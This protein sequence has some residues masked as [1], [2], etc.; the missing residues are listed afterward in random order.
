MKNRRLTPASW[1]RAGA[2]VLAV[3]ALGGTAVAAAQDAEPPAND[4]YLNSLE[5][6]QAGTPLDHTHTLRDV[7][8]TTNAT[9]QTD[10]F[11]PPESGGGAEDTICHNVSYGKTVWYDV[12][13]DKDGTVSIR[14]SGYDN[15]I[16]FYEFDPDTLIPDAGTKHCVNRGSFPSEQMVRNV[17][18]GKS[19]TVQIGGVGDVG[20]S[21]EVLFDYAY[22]KLAKLAADATLTAGATPNGIELKG[23]S[24]KTSKKATVSVKCG[25]HCK[26]QSKKNHAVE[27]FGALKG[28]KMPAGSKLQ[29]RVTAPKSIGVYIEYRVGAGSF[30]KVTRCLKPGSKTPRKTCR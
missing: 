13:P 22:E 15:V 11:N 27:N 3:L 24:V 1:G 10:I 16:T 21:L 14:T 28:V 7:R 23:L 2:A 19:Y 18:K 26:P 9:T 6:N 30:K 20:G 12:H 17:K 29:I 8:D 25:G 4:A 5:L